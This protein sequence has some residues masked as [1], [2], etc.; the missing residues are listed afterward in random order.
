MASVAGAIDLLSVR[1][2]CTISELNMDAASTKQNIA[3]AVTFI[4]R[5]KNVGLSSLLDGVV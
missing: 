3:N 5:V 4:F 2:L 1:F